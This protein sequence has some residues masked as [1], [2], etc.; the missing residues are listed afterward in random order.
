MGIKSLNRYFLE[1]CG[2]KS[3]CK[4]HLRDFANKTLVIDTSIYLYKFSA[5]GAL[6][7]N[8]YL[9]ISIFKKYRIEPIFV[10]DGKP[11]SEKKNVLLQRRLEKKEAQDKYKDLKN[12]LDNDGVDEEKRQQLLADMESLKR[13]FVRIKEQDIIK[14][15]R[16]MDSYGVLYYDAL[17]E[18][19]VLC[20]Y[21]VKTGRAWACVSDDMDMFVYGC[22]RVIRHISML[23]HTA[24]FYDTGRILKDI[25]MT[26]DVFRDIMVLSGT[27]YNM[28]NET[29]LVETLKWY[30]EYNKSRPADT[31]KFYEWLL[32]HTRYIKDINGLMNVKQMFV[33]DNYADILN[34]VDY[35]NDAIKCSNDI[36]LKTLLREEGFIFA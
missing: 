29:N 6:I 22:D 1:N 5:D 8:M 12:I 14:T 28:N 21:L 32:K 10:F 13:Q 26:E 15:K 11:P 23:N 27:D 7:E 31:A 2:K 36:D 25:N 33:L 19:D 34:S 17:G 9:M 16:L 4:T 35:K 30:N 3:I 18:A 24:I 20:C